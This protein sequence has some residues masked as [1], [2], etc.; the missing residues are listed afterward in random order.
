MHDIQ[1]RKYADARALIARGFPMKTV[2]QELGLTETETR[3]V[4]GVSR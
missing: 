1:E 4:V 3:L 2:A